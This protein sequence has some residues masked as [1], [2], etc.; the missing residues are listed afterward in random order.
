[1]KQ[2]LNKLMNLQGIAWEEQAAFST[3]LTRLPD[4]LLHL[5]TRVDHGKTVLFL[6]WV[7]QLGFLNN[8]FF[9]KSGYRGRAANQACIL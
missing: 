4:E 6:P 5:A 8:R 2:R 9:V 1:V 7:F 3:A